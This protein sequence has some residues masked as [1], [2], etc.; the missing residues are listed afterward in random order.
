ML[1]PKIVELVFLAAC[2]GALIAGADELDGINADRCP[3]GHPIRLTLE[4]SEGSIVIDLD[5]KA[6]PDAVAKIAALARGPVFNPLFITEQPDGTSAG[7][8]D[9]LFFDR[10]FPGAEIATEIRQ[11]RTA[12]QLPVQIDAEALGLDLRTI[13]TTAEAMNIWQHEI[14]PYEGSIHGR[15]DPHPILAGWL[16]EW[17]EE[18][19]PDFLVG[20][21]QLDI[22]LAV[23]YRTT[24]GLP[25]IPVRRGTVALLSS[26]RN[27][28]TPAL[29]IILRDRPDQ[30]GRRM[31]VGRVVDGLELADAWSRRQLTPTK[32]HS[33]RPLDPVR[34]ISS[35]IVCAP[36][37]VSQERSSEEDS[38]DQ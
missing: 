5:P 17:R 11:P 32:R 13:D 24:P 22:N 21:S 36:S 34:I 14:L 7:Y 3:D 15:E 8:Y 18:M 31:V 28:A 9:G 23:G 30:D 4:T 35:H 33:N 19:E 6:A 38:H 29:A 2:G 26:S 1:R 10:A 37:T 20:A 12:I 16:A 27:S 25:S